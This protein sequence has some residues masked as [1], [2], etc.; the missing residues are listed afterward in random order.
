MISKMEIS[1]SLSLTFALLLSLS[2][3]QSFAT[4]Y[5]VSSSGNDANAG[6]TIGA[7]WKTISKVNG[8]IFLPGDGL[9]FEG[10][11]TFTGSIF[12]PSTDA[13]DPNNIFTI[14]S[15]GSGKATINGGTSNG[16]Y[17]YNTQGF[18]ISNLIFDGNSVVTNNGVGI[19]V[20]SDLPGDVKFS[21]IVVNN[22]EIKNFGNEGIKIYT[23][24]NLTGFENV[25][26]SHLSVHDV[27][28]NG[29]IVYGYIAQTLIGWQHK[30]VTV[31][32]C[33]IYN[34]P[35]SGST[36]ASSHEG[37]GIVL[38]G[39]DGGM[40]QYCVAHDNGQ[41]NATCGGPVGIWT[42][43]SNNI[44]IEYCESYKNHNGSGCDGAGF[45]LDGGVT[46]SFMQYNY[47][48]DNDGAGYLLGQYDHARPWT[49]NTMRY[50]IS[51]NDGVNNEGGIYLFK[52]P[53]TSMSGANIYQNTI[54]TSP[55]AGNAS[56]SV[57]S[58]KNWMTGINNVNFFN[59]ILIS[60]GG[61]PLI[62]IPSGYSGFFAGNLYWASGNSFAVNY[63]GVHYST[64]S[65]WS[66]ATNNEIVNGT[67]TGANADP[68]VTNPGSGGTIGFGVSLTSLNSYKISSITSPAYH[69][70]LD[71]NSLY[72]INIGN[73]DFWGSVLSGGTANDIGANQYSA[74]LPV[75]L[76]GFHGSCSGNGQV[77]SWI[78]AE[79]I[80]MMSF[81]LMYSLDGK[82]FDK[83]ADIKPLGS[84]SHYNYS[85]EGI[86]AGNNYYQLKMIDLDGKVNYSPM[87][88]L[89]CGSA[90]NKTTVGPNPFGQFI[91]IYMANLIPGI[92]KLTIYDNLGKL[93]SQQYL[94]LQTGNNTFQVDALDNFSPGVY[95]LTIDSKEQTEH[96]KII[97]AN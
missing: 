41:K 60:T 80:N 19:L 37:N 53:S 96:F 81:E 52:G 58:Y 7:A 44:I 42:L 49:N 87:L 2:S 97:K 31:S 55:Q 79:E 86:H 25:S 82:A 40:I 63:Q 36:S 18:T 62:N 51:E 73:T 47:S 3:T 27:T 64:L 72:S 76:L 20:F 91:N 92:A 84:N 46:N 67:S 33:E 9:Y 32:N 48:H 1:N 85:K 38:E 45:D 93:L 65:S 89:Q 95:Y 90:N 15:Y 75:Q 29:I 74:T 70:S 94:Q 66:T 88:D 71:L 78:T 5:Y 57:V 83:L 35:G 59:N 22:V 8:T 17:A 68:L 39:V 21:N 50:N 26:L 54:Y 11:Q 14:S 69:Q 28:K 12:L 30:N 24:I 6:T 13:N 34:V 4:D 43:E 10:G 61:I 77:I 23:T 16:L 56:L